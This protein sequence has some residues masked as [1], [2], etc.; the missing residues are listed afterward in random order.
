MY[1]ITQEQR[2]RYNAN[3]RAKKAAETP[4]Q[5]AA[6]LAKR[7]EDY[8]KQVERG[9]EELRRRTR[10]LALAYVN[11]RRAANPN[12]ENER[13]K[14]SKVRKEQRAAERLARVKD[15]ERLCPRCLFIKK[16]E[17]FPMTRSGERSV[18]CAHCYRTMT[19]QYDIESSVFWR[20]KATALKHRSKRRAKDG[21]VIGDVTADDLRSIYDQQDHRCA[22]CGIPLN[23]L[24]IAIDHKLPLAKGGSHVKEN[25]Q[26]LCH[27]CNVSKFTMSDED[28][29][30]YFLDSF[31]EPLR[32]EPSS[33]DGT[34][35]TTATEIDC[36]TSCIA[37]VHTKEEEL[38]EP[39]NT[40]ASVQGNLQPNSGTDIWDIQPDLG[41]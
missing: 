1:K 14:R 41:F 21:A 39:L 5:R 35:S 18:V 15:G 31:K 22:Y 28:Y 6:R 9:G 33:P 23:A 29:R 27:N 40:E 8:R 32:S 25:I 24:I 3:R 16:E 37:D 19:G 2:D 34:L 38:Q 4:E 12:Y 17:D 13:Y 30:K 7:R 11:K 26:L 10:E 20:N 36:S